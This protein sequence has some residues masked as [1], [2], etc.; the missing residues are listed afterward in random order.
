MM[1]I[2]FVDAGNYS[3]SPAAERVTRKLL[4]EA[5]RANGVDVGEP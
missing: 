5:L 3:R 2:L 1:R 4:A